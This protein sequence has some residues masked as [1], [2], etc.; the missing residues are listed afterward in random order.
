MK[1]AFTLLLAL[2]AFTVAGGS[3]FIAEY[4]TFVAAAGGGGSITKVQA[5]TGTSPGTTATV[6]PSS[7]CTAGNTVMIGI[8]HFNGATTNNTCVD[9]L[10]NSLTK[11]QSSDGSSNHCTLWYY[12]VPS[13]GVT[14]FSCSG[15]TGSSF[16]IGIMYEFSGLNATTPFTTGEKNGNGYASGAPTAHPA[17]GNITTGT[18]NSVVVAFW[19]DNSTVMAADNDATNAVPTTGWLTDANAIQSSGSFELGRF[20][21][22]IFSSTGTYQCG[23]SVTSVGSQTT[24]GAAFH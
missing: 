14:S 8:A 15:G 17:T 2:A 1:T 3:G 24:A 22:R 23:W 6:T 11:V 5:K 4:E 7:A 18:A 20:T 19:S 16:T 21:Y 9:N 12:V 13:G 10:S